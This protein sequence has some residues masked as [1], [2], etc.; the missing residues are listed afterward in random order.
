MSSRCPVCRP[1]RRLLQVLSADVIGSDRG[2]RQLGGERDRHVG[3]DAGG[4]GLV[5]A[6]A[7]FVHLKKIQALSTRSEP[8]DGCLGGIVAAAVGTNF[9]VHRSVAGFESDGDSHLTRVLGIGI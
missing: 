8:L 3:G 9:N 5:L 7:V 1:V 2:Q 6:D 4:R